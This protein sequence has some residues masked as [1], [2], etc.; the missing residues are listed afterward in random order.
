MALNASS[1]FPQGSS[2]RK[3]PE[4]LKGLK[5][6]P[7]ERTW[8]EALGGSARHILYTKLDSLIINFKNEWNP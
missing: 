4:F 2:V 6:K 8:E 7:K 1:G 5:K 3:S